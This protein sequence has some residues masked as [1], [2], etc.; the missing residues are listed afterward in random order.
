MLIRLAIVEDDPRFRSAFAE[1]IAAASDM[2]LVATADD[3]PAGLELLEGEALDV[4]LVDLGL[5]SGRSRFD[6]AGSRKLAGLRRDRGVDL[7]R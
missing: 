4:M 5:P 6:Q 1:A 3:L 7:W 2:T